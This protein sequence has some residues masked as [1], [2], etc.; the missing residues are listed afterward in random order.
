MRKLLLTA[1]L[2]AL[3]SAGALAQAPQGV[4]PTAAVPQRTEPGRYWVF[5]AWNR[6][7]LP[8]DGRKVVEEAAQSFLRTGSAR[9]SL[10]GSADRT[11][12]PAYNE[13]LSARRADAV[14]AEL[15]RLGVPADAIA[16]RAEGENAPHRRDRRR[17]AR[18]AQPLCRDR[19]PG[20]RDAA[21]SAASGAHRTAGAGTGEGRPLAVQHHALCLGGGAQG[22][23]RRGQDGRRCRRELQGH[24]GQSQ[25]RPDARGRVAQG[26]LR[27][28]LR[29]AST[30]ISRTMQPR[31]TAGSRSTPP[32]SCSSSPWP[33]PTVSA[34]GS[35]PTSAAPGR[36][37]VTVDP[38]AGARYTYLTAELQGKLDLPDLGIDA[39]RTAEQSEHW[40]DPIVGLRTAWT[41]GE[42]WNLVVA[43]DVGGIS[44]SDQYS[45]E[46]WGRSAIGSGCSAR[47]RH[48]A[49]RLPRPE[50]EVRERR[51]PRP[52]QLG[53]DHP[54]PDRR[55]QDHVLTGEKHR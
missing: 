40:V 9:I 33:A 29:H 25:W 19:L 14:R 6:A 27:A 55:A 43:G 7:E 41:L 20:A 18:A 53:H 17:R 13:K 48:R 50:A 47:Q 10:V 16:I 54:W 23:R 21:A 30:P 51:R 4:V 44:T 11:G 5:F 38:Y 32:A 8:P 26:P 46:A 2:L 22:R 15:V 52:L 42:H 28:D 24:P 35:S 49:R 36:S 37:S 31:A 1:S 39:R 45:A 3:A 12:S 34:P